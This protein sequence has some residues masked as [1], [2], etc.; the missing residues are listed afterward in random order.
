MKPLFCLVCWP[1]EDNQMSVVS[2]KKIVSPH[3]EKL[4]V[5]AFCKVIKFEKCVCRVV[6]VGTNT[7]MTKKLEE[8]EMEEEL[9][10]QQEEDIQPSP[11]KSHVRCR[12][13]GTV[14]KLS[15]LP[16]RG[17]ARYRG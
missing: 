16:R 14:R 7:E 10:K 8:V 2:T 5:E 4:A 13:K 15:I 11:K 12:R 9:E 1:E 3:L 17:H 6:A